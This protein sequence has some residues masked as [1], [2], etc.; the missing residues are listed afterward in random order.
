[1]SIS[2][3][4]RRKFKST[5]YSEVEAYLLSLRDGVYC[6][7][8]LINA[9]LQI[10][11][12]K[13]KTFPKISPTGIPPSYPKE[14]PLVDLYD[15]WV[16]MDYQRKIQLAKL[17][18]FLKKRG[19][20]NTRQSGTIDYAMRN[21]GRKFVWDGLGRCL[22]AGMIGMKQITFFATYHPKG[23][24][25]KDAQKIEAE[26]FTVRNGQV[27]KPKSEEL[28]KAYV[29]QE[30]PDA[31]KKLETLKKCDLDIEGLIPSSKT[32]L[33]GF[34]AFDTN[35][36]KMTEK[37]WIDA[38]DIIQTA[39]SDMKTVAVYGLTGVAHTLKMN[40][41]LG[42]DAYTIEQIKTGISKWRSNKW[43]KKERCLQDDFFKHGFR[44]IDLIGYLVCTR[45]LG[46]DPVTGPLVS[47][48]G[49]NPDEKEMVDIAI[50]TK[51]KKAA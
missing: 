19:G 8:D 34:K 26:D 48:M 43:K 27:R 20:F 3:Q 37:N 5:K 33:T 10:G 46:E 1:M 41:F 31:M 21:D 4:L 9:I 2:R 6:V 38:S 28:F 32:L 51:I 7:G 18:D 36:E 11:N 16:D 13:S 22:M 25:D 14:T 44:R 42:K 35:Y 15:L 24:S 12:F 29:C 30:L 23:T 50:E 39:W 49:L 45:A 47:L 40:E 17:I